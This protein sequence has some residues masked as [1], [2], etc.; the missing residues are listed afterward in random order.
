MKTVTDRHDDEQMDIDHD[1]GLE[2]YEDDITIL[3]PNNS[4]TEI[5]PVRQPLSKFSS[6]MCVLK[7]CFLNDGVKTKK[8]IY[9]ILVKKIINM[10]FGLLLL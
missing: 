5:T 3:S 6:C 9:I 7:F 10:K 8:N 2:T 4:G 1:T